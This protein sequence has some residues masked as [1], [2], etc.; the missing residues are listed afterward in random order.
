MHF[1]YMFSQHFAPMKTNQFRIR[2]LLERKPIPTEFRQIRSISI[3]R[4]F[5][6]ET[7]IFER[8]RLPEN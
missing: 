2:N 7:L 1:F 4:E 8:G 5:R 6:R 3:A